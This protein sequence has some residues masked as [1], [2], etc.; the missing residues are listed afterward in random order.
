LACSN[1]Y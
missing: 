1:R